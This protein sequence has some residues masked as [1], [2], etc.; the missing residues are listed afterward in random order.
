MNNWYAI[1]CE[2]EFRR[3]EWQRAVAADA[4]AAL[5]QAGNGRKPWPRLSL[6]SPR[7]LAATRLPFS[8]PLPPRRPAPCLPLE[9]CATA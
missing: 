1:E 7:S 5:A 2:A 6:A 4:R 3:R 8:S 9:R